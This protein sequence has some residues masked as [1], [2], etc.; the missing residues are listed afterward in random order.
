MDHQNTLPY[1]I[2][3]TMALAL[4]LWLSPF[5][6]LRRITAADIWSFRTGVAL[7][8]CMI[9]L[10]ALSALFSSPIQPHF[11]LGLLVLG[12]GIGLLLFGR[13]FDA[14]A[15]SALGLAIDTLLIC[16]FARM[17][18][19]NSWRGEWIGALFFLG[20]F[21]AGLVAATAA[22]IRMALRRAAEQGEQA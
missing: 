17:L 22:L 1:F 6:S 16:G 14:F 20:L 3:W 9:T 19:S 2:G 11:V 7:A 4:S 15:L 12:T 10:T 5:P 18:F 8:S 21:S 13:V